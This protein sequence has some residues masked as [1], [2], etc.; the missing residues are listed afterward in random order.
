MYCFY[1]KV[2]QGHI[3]CRCM[4]VVCTSESLYSTVLMSQDLTIL[5]FAYHRRQQ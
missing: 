4:E 5:E 1:G 2:N 3:V